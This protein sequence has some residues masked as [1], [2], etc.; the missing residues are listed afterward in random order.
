MSVIGSIVTIVINYHVIN[1]HQREINSSQTSRIV[2]QL[3]RVH[4][5]RQFRG[6]ILHKAKRYINYYERELS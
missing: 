5:E 3:H 2:I 4:T 1:A 6:N